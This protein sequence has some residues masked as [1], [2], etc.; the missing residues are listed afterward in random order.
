MTSTELL[1]DL[2]MQT[3]E[4][5]VGKS[6][7]RCTDGFSFK[8]EHPDEVAKTFDKSR[9][10]LP[11]VILMSGPSESGKSTFGRVLSSERVATRFKILRLVRELSEQSKIPPHPK[12]G[13]EDP[14]LL[15]Q[16]IHGHGEE[17]EISVGRTIVDGVIEKLEKW[18]TPIA[19]V[20][21]I[22]FP[23]LI[24]AFKRH[25]GIRSL[26]VFLN[27]NRNLRIAREAEKENLTLADAAKF[28]DLKDK[29]K[30]IAGVWEIREMADIVVFNNAPTTREFTL[31]VKSLGQLGLSYS[32]AFTG[33]PHEYK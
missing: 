15:L 2:L 1:D 5:R 27:P 13:S 6:E 7:I 20:E 14:I 4:H 8:I 12:L 16:H 22:S 29:A 28:T 21:T 10:H 31:L 25:E 24:K 3:I 30:A 11:L 9:S 32:R 33:I 18:D 19:V 23:W 26:S 17:H